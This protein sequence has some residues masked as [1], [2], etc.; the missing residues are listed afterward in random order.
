M[1]GVIALALFGA[2]GLAQFRLFNNPRDEAN[3]AFETPSGKA[4]IETYA[5]LRA[6]Y[7]RDVPPEQLMKGALVGMLDSLRDEFTYYLEPETSATQGE[8]IKGEFFG[9][10]VSIGPVGRDGTGVLVESVFVGQPAATAGV[11]VGDIIVKVNGEDVTK[12]TVTQAVRKIRGPKGSTVKLTVQRGANRLD[13]SMQRDRIQVINVNSTMLPGQIGYVAITDFLNQNVTAQLQ[14][15]LE[16]L[17]AKGAKGVILD[18]RN[19]PG[20]LVTQAQGVADTFLAK[21]DVF[22]TRDRSQKVTVEYAAKPQRTDYN[23]PLV[24]LVNTGSASASEIV[25]AAIQENGRGR[26]VG[27]Q[28]YGKGVANTPTKLSNGAQ[29]NIAFEEWLTPKRNSIFKK[30]VTP[31]VKVE[32]SRYP[33]LLAFEGVNAK[34]GSELE[35]KV[36][37]KTLKLKADA[38]GRFTYQDEPQRVRTSDRQGSA[39]VNLETDGI[40][41]KALEMLTGTAVKR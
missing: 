29:V 9:I 22:I 6:S 1:A 13:L 25:S 12:L 17:R 18:L 20:G 5:A 28:T 37:G 39:L 2:I 30:G 10:G 24:V 41:R 27:E 40:A 3:K 19:N 23:G 16:G 14:T 4:F 35:V 36:N 15:A 31:D 11:Q 32:D 38:Q 8:E 34:P 21:G 33:R 26:I 7:L